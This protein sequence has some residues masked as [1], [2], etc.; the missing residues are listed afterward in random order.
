MEY[1]QIC[2]ARTGMQGSGSG[3]QTLNVSEGVPGDAVA[4]FSRAQS[5]SVGSVSSVS[6][7]G[8]LRKVRELRS[9]GPYVFLTTLTYG[10]P[11]R[12]R[13]PSAFA[14]G[15]VFDRA[16]FE[17]DPQAALCVADESFGFTEE[18]TK[19]E[20]VHVSLREPLTLSR[21]REAIGLG[22]EAYAALLAC[23]Y[24][25]MSVGGFVGKPFEVE[26]DCSE[27]TLHALLTCI[28]Q[29]I[30]YGLRDKV[31]FSTLSTNRGMPTNVVFSEK[32]RGKAFSLQ[33]GQV[34]L[35]QPGQAQ[36]PLRPRYDCAM[37]PICASGSGVDLDSVFDLLERRVA[38]FCDDG[39]AVPFAYQ[40]AYERLAEEGRIPR[41]PG[42]EHLFDA[43]TL[44]ERLAG[45]LALPASGDRARLLERDRLIDFALGEII[46][47][48]VELDAEE[49]GRLDATL[50]AT[51]LATLR[52]TGFSYHVRV[53]VRRGTAGG[54]A[55]L[56]ERFPSRESRSTAA[57]LRLR[58]ALMGAPGGAEIVEALYADRVSEALVAQGADLTPDALLAFGDETSFLGSGSRAE[59]SYVELCR[60]FALD[61][62]PED[63][64]PQQFSRYFGWFFKKMRLSPAAV[65]SIWGD[66]LG[67]YWA[68]FSFV[69]FTFDIGYYDSVLNARC[70]QYRALASASQ[71]V[72]DVLSGHEELLQR[73]IPDFISAL[74]KLEDRE[75]ATRLFNRTVDEIL[76]CDGGL[77]PYG[78]DLWYGVAVQLVGGE[79]AT[80]FLLGHGVIPEDRDECEELLERAV[81]L[82]ESG[83]LE[84]I[85]ADCEELSKTDAP[86][87]HLASF[88][89]RSIKGQLKRIRKEDKRA[90]RAESHGSPRDGGLFRRKGGRHS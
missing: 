41:L 25:S 70:P 55:Y 17:R 40:L 24:E 20:N 89:A 21:A 87:A 46:E 37:L 10:V 2:Y 64:D 67:A 90:A 54:S 36:S 81:G 23:V 66:V 3:W 45:C 77:A 38:T 88:M 1:R 34:T 82:R 28:Y 72:N 68:K 52:E 7:A 61:K 83:A 84:R 13:R 71:L 63:G 8:K 39:A 35:A 9:V 43:K 75:S 47:Y 85:M 4:A 76:P 69:S 56:F 80:E 44:R 58:D 51:E 65:N 32:A 11:D 79:R 74:D 73:H 27:E 86:Y 53:L 29:G 42:E 62:V 18:A 31:A 5:G 19:P 22:D 16:A 49:E 78:L 59:R 33:T 57:F 6:P 48:D 50:D 14:H 60:L 30:P 15:F 12:R 26:C